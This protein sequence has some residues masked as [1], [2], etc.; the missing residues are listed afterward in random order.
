MSNYAIAI[1][2]DNYAIPEWGLDGAVQDA[3]D[4]AQWALDHGDVPAQ[5]LRLLLSPLPGRALNLP[6]GVVPQSVKQATSQAIRQTIIDFKNGAGKKGK[7]LYLYFAGHGVS[8]P[9]A[10]QAWLHEPV[11]VPANITDI[12]V[13]SNLFLG[14]TWILTSL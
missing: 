8:A 14:F 12:D 11:L 10:A 2:I 7:R 3:L 5:N 1:G 4:F 13:D 9:G 6:A